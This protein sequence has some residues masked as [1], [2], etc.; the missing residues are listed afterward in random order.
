MMI[1]YGFIKLSII[2]FYRRLFV[3]RKGT[4]FDHIMKLMGVLVLLW[5]VTFILMVVFA[6]NTTFWA[7]WGSTAAQ[8]QHCPIG[9]TSE[10]GLAIS[11]FILDIVIILMPLPQVIILLALGVSSF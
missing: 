4:I 1:A 2:S 10:Y 9:F 5:T 3:T 6:C 8:L 11:D 7:N